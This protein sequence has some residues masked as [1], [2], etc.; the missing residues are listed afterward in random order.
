M[1]WDSGN[2]VC[3]VCECS[4]MINNDCKV[5]EPCCSTFHHDSCMEKENVQQNFNN[6]PMKNESDLSLYSSSSPDRPTCRRFSFNR[7]SNQGFPLK[8]H[9]HNSQDSGY[10]AGCTSD[11]SKFFEFARSLGVT[12]RQCSPIKPCSLS[13][14]SMDSMDDEFFEFADLEKPMDENAQLPT[15]FNSLINCPFPTTVSSRERSP[16]M[17]VSH[18]VQLRR[19]ISLDVSENTPNSSRVR[20]CLFKKDDMDYRS[21]KRP[22]PPITSKSPIQNKRSKVDENTCSVPEIESSLLARQ[23]PLF[24]RSISATEESIKYALQR[25]SNEP[26]LIGDFSTAFCLPLISG[27][28][29]DLK[30]ITPN[31]LAAL[32]KGEYRNVVNSFK[33]IDCRYPYEYN[34]G[35]IEDA[36]NLYTKEQIIAHLLDTPI[37]TSDKSLRNILVFHCEFSSERGPNLYRFL[38]KCDRLRNT[39]VYPALHY[40]EIYLLEGGYKNFFEQY[41]G[42][43]VPNTYLPMLDSNHSDDLRHFRAK[44]K[45]WNADKFRLSKALS[46][47]RLGFP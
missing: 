37:A 9:D 5:S 28:H 1:F 3:E 10:D 39:D 36:T 24:R 19:A 2:A 38:R 20:S 46:F 27:R 35:H 13:F 34:G 14:G 26:D 15:D 40:P 21:F 25:S 31:T 4:R 6:S 8:D 43:C 16:D 42:L 45:T 7:C 29:Q 41:S 32:M 47:K 12:P 22:E 17:N 18:T 44:S 23:R 33:V 11:E 30:S